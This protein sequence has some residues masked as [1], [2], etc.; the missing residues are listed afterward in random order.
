MTFNDQIRRSGARWAL[1]AFVLAL[2]WCWLK[3]VLS[4]DAKAA[5]SAAQLQELPSA[6]GDSVCDTAKNALTP[7]A[8]L[9]LELG[10]A[11]IALYLWPLPWR[12]HTR[13][14]RQYPPPPPLFPC[15]PH[16]LHCVFLE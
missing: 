12:R 2:S 5:F 15:R 6:T 10:M 11:V 4:T 13:G 8:Q 1:L 3:P 7:G 9:A 14:T 16:Q